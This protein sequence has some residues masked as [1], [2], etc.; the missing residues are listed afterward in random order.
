[1][2]VGV[3]DVHRGVV[4]VPPEDHIAVDRDA[5]GCADGDA[6]LVTGEGG[7]VYGDGDV[8]D[9]LRLVVAAVRKLGCR[10][11]GKVRD[12]L[13]SDEA[14]GRAVVGVRGAA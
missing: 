1:M 4:D 9:K 10:A 3:T 12:A 14:C 2:R 11:R 8:R 7:A 13:V 5:V 6:A